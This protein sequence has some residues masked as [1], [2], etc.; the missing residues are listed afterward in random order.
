MEL[1]F[2]WLFFQHLQGSQGVFFF[3]VPLMGTGECPLCWSFGSGWKFIWD[4]ISCSHSL[5]FQET[6]GC[7][8]LKSSAF[9]YLTE[10]W[11]SNFFLSFPCCHLRSLT[12][13]SNKESEISWGVC[14]Y[15]KWRIPRISN[16]SGNST[17]SSWQR[18]LMD[19]VLGIVSDL[20]QLT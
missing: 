10:T 12:S 5:V 16:S 14:A 19:L 18:K 11:K 8:G 7:F 2:I 20:L 4:S 15:Q 13:S 1:P 17:C 3:I 9:L 6:C